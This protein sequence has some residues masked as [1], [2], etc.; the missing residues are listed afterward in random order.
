MKARCVA[1]GFMIAI[2]AGCQPV[3]RPARSIAAAGF[4]RLELAAGDSVI[5]SGVTDSWMGEILSRSRRLRISFDIGH[6]AGL[7]M[8]PARKAESIWFRVDTLN[9]REVHA[10]LIAASG[11]RQFVVTIPG[12]GRDPWSLPANFWATVG[13][14]ADMAEVMR[15]ARSYRPAG[16]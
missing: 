2:A 7:H 9:G 11:Q 3:P 1:V 15:L 14:D 8:S 10:G 4:G 6:M 12:T 5:R 16:Q 13:G